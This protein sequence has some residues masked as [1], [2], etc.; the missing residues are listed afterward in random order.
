LGPG[1]ITAYS[2]GYLAFVAVGDPIDGYYRTRSIDGWHQQSDGEFLLECSPLYQ[3]TVHTKHAD[4]WHEWLTR[5]H[6]PGPSS[7][8]IDLTATQP[9]ELSSE[10]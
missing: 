3:I 8:I 5:C 7:V 9:R 2:S 4:A 6:G 10:S 1:E